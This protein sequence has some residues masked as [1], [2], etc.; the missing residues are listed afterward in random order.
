MTYDNSLFAKVFKGITEKMDKATISAMQNGE[1]EA[2]QEYYS[3]LDKKVKDRFEEIAIEKREKDNQLY[4][5]VNKQKEAQKEQGS[6]TPA[7]HHQSQKSRGKE[8]GD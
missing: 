8:I 3:T 6:S 5:E 7:K 1:K 4:Q 2:E